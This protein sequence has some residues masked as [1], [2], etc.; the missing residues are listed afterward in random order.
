MKPKNKDMSEGISTR[1]TCNSTGTPDPSISWYFENKLIKSS[2]KYQVK[3]TA[4]LSVLVIR[5][6][7]LDDVGEYMVVAENDLGKCEANFSLSV[8]GVTSKPPPEFSPA[9]KTLSDKEN[10]G[11]LGN[12]DTDKSVTD[13]TPV[14]VEMYVI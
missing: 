6:T 11:S 5:E 3:N 4:G 7:C 2:E 8:D 12:E 9:S 10:E 14:K 13:R 1:F